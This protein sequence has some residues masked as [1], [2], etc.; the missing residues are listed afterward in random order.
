MKKLKKG[1]KFG[2]KKDARK[3]F[4]NSLANNLIT[5]EKIKTT[6]ARAKELSSFVEKLITKAKKNELATMKNLVRCLTLESSRKLIKEIAPKYKD[7]NGGYTRIIK[8][9]PRKSDGARLA[10]IE[11]VNE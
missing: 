7:R 9:N 10:I 6:E 11:F 2:K 8:M 1:R 4:L 5:R 3:A